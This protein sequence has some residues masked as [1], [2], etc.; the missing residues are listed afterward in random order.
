M[1]K[2]TSA[3]AFAL[4]LGLAGAS[5]ATTPKFDEVD[6]NDD[7]MVSKSEAA[8]VD[9]LDFAKADANGD[10]HLT[11]AEYEAAIG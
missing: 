9:G 4:A 5:F 2:W 7:G 1:R 8:K 10:G 11:R 3:L 6:S